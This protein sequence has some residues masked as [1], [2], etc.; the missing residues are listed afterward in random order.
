MSVPEY[1]SI[2]SDA[3]LKY[4]PTYPDD[5]IRHIVKLSAQHEAVWDCAT[6]NGQAALALAEHFD[7][8]YATDASKGQLS[9][10]Q[11]ADN[12]DYSFVPAE[13]SELPESSVDCITVAQ[14]LHW[15]PTDAFYEEAMRV[16]RPGAVLAAWCYP[17]CH[18]DNSEI[19]SVF[20]AFCAD[21]ASYF[22]EG[23]HH[24][25]EGYETIY[26]PLKNVETHTFHQDLQ[27]TQQQFLGYLCTWSAV[28]CYQDQNGH[29]PLEG[30][31]LAEFEDAWPDEDKKEVV[32]FDFVLKT[33]RF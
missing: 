7:Q 5:L 28:K 21:M 2:E 15:F 18:L 10:A 6:G 27:W 17:H 1:F 8:V 30:F 24:L 9:E 14:A 25:D 16:A 33:G 23:R 29:H 31:W 20:E 11:Q 4:R 12:I 19:Q 26:F 3:Y 22:P 32:H 13:E